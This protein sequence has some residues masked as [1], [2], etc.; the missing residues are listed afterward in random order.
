MIKFITVQS[1]IGLVFDFAQ[2]FYYT[3]TK[4]IFFRIVFLI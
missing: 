3:F 2:F 4:S 1:Q